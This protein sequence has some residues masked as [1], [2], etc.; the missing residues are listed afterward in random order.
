MQWSEVFYFVLLRYPGDLQSG[1]PSQKENMRHNQKEQCFGRKN[2]CEERLRLAGYHLC[3]QHNMHIVTNSFVTN[4]TSSMSPTLS[5]L[6]SAVLILLYTL[7][8][9]HELDE[10][11]ANSP[12][13][14]VMDL[15]R[16]QDINNWVPQ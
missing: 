6:P 12:P 3:R 5:P 1:C 2:R 8:A 7:Q 16:L 9:S 15:Q 10:P 4:N 14:V 11:I 13:S